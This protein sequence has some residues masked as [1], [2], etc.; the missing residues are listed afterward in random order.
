MAGVDKQ[1]YYSISEESRDILRRMKEKRI[2]G[3]N[4]G[5]KNNEL[6]IGQECEGEYICDELSKEDCLALSN[7]FRELSECFE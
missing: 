1:K 4:I 3:T 7:L 5:W 6:L 2:F